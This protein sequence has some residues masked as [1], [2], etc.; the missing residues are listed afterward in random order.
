MTDADRLKLLLGP[1]KRPVFKYGDDGFCE[2][3]GGVILSG[4]TDAP[5]PWPLG[6][7]RRKGS[8]P[9]RP[10]SSSG[11]P[12]RGIIPR[13]ISYDPKHWFRLLF[14]WRGTVLPRVLPRVASFGLL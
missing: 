2:L 10:T 1:Y 5:I 13:M 12:R 11:R 9:Q 3:R 7:K 14:H 8:R 6:K 4:L